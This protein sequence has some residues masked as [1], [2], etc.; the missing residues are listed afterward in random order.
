M[1]ARDDGGAAGLLGAGD[2]AAL[3][4]ASI[5][6]PDAARK[7]RLSIIVRPPTRD[8]CSPVVATNPQEANF[9]QPIQY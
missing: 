8:E 1:S 2:C 6:A 5:D 4:V 7:L 9:S 3:T